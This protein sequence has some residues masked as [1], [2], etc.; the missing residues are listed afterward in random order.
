MPC[1]FSWPDGFSLSYGKGCISPAPVNQWDLAA[2]WKQETSTYFL[3]DL[4]PEQVARKGV[5][6][7]S[8]NLSQF[9]TGGTNR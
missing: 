4:A 8:L 1:S 7:L 6:K 5:S 9:G 3:Q 2:A